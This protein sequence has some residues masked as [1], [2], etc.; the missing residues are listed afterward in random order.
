MAKI[1]KKTLSWTPG[2]AADIVA[3]KL[4]WCSEEEVL[5][6]DSPNVTIDMPAT[7]IT[8]PEDAPNFPLEE[9]NFQIGI[10]SVDDVGNESD[11]AEL[12]VPFDFAA[13]DAPT[14]LVVEDV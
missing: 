1:I 6:Y 3:T 13:P 9:G 2:A 14:N 8:L 11:I 12:A 7:E 10:T 4:Y 5:T